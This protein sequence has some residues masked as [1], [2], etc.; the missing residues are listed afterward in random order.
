MQLIQAIHHLERLFVPGQESELLT[1][2]TPEQRESWLKRGLISDALEPKS[3]GESLLSQILSLLN[4]KRGETGDPETHLETL[5]RVIEEHGSFESELKRVET[6]FDISWKEVQTEL[7]Q[8]RTALARKEEQL[9]AIQNPDQTGAQ[10]ALQTSNPGEV[11][12]QNADGGATSNTPIGTTLQIREEA[13]RQNA[14]IG[15]SEGEQSGE[16]LKLVV[17]APTTISASVLSGA[18]SP[19]VALALI[20]KGLNT[21]ESLRAASDDELRAIEGIG[22]S[23][24]AKLRALTTEPVT[25]QPVTAQPVTA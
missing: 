14:Q 17:P 7:D 13:Q 19:R 11:T 25:A 4:K 18:S 6:Q 3:E 12:G 22:D 21:V 10:I 5:E 9:Y 2:S 1:A 8:L 24:L 16:P 23:T 20:E 15:T